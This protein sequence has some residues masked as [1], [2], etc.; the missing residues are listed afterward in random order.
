MFNSRKLA[1]SRLASVFARR[2]AAHPASAP[3]LEVARLEDRLNPAPM[4]AIQGLA[5]PGATS[6]LIGETAN[7]TFDFVNTAGGAGATDTGYAPYLEVAVDT[8]GRDG[9]GIDGNTTTPSQPND[10]FSTP[11]LTAGGLQLPPIG[12]PVVLTVGQTTYTNP[13]TGQTRPVPTGFGADDTIYVYQ[14]PFGSFTPGQRTAV[15]VSAPTSNLADVNS[16]LP[17]SFT[18]GFRDDDPGTP[19]GG[20]AGPPISGGTAATDATPELYRLRKVYLGPEDETAT[21]PNYPRTY[22]L[23]VDVATGQT[24]DNL[25][26]SDDLADSMR[27]TGRTTA[28]MSAF[29]ASSGLTN[30]VFN[31]AN[32]GGTATTAA[33]DGT[34]TYNFGSVTGVAGVDAAFEFEF[35][36]PRDRA[37]PPGGQVLPQTPTTGT[38]SVF[39]TNTASSTANWTPIDTRDPAG[40]VNK[41]ASDNGPHTLQEQSIATQ[42]SVVETDLNQNPLPSGS[43]IRPGQTLLR[44]TVNFQVSDY[45]AFQNVTLQDLIG[46]GQRLYLGAS[47]ND[48]AF[49]PTLQVSN[50]YEFATT[51]GARSNTAGAFGG[52]NILYRQLFTSNAASN[53]IGYAPAG[54]TNSAFTNLAPI[55]LANTNVYDG[56]TFLQ[57]NVSDELIRRLGADG[58]RLVGGDISNTGVGPAN[59]PFGSQLFSGTTGTIVFYAIVTDEFSD[60]FENFGNSNDPSVDQGDIL[61]NRIPLDN[62]ADAQ[63]AAGGN[64]NGFTGVRGDQINPTT[65]NAATPLVI[66]IGTDDTASAIELAVGEQQKTVYAINGTVIPTQGPGD[67]VFS[68]QAADAVTY[69]LTYTLPISRFENL[70]L[71]DL[72]PLP[73]IP[74]GPA[75]GYTFTGAAPTFTVGEIALAP[76]DTFFGTFGISPTLSTD[77]DANSL[78]LTYGSFDDVQ[79]RSTTISLLVTFRVGSQGF[80]NDLFLTNQLRVNEDTTNQ[81]TVSVEDLRRFELVRPFVTVNKGAV[82]GNGTGL[83]A[84]GIAFTAPNTAP[85]FTVGG[86]AP[87]STNALDT[88]AEAIAVGGLNVTPANLP[89]DGAD[90][91]RYA[92]VVQNTGRGDTF[93]ATIAD[94]VPDRYDRASFSGPTVFRGD[95]TLLIAGVDYTFTYNSGTGAL[96]ITLV[97]NYTAG[98]VNS[99]VTSLDNRSGALSRGEAA[100]D[101]GGAVP[102]TNGSNTI[103][104]LYDVTLLNTVAPNEL[105]VNTASV[106]VYSS[107]EGGTDLTD[108]AQVP[109]AVDPTDTANV[110]IA[111]PLQ[112]KTLVGTEVTETGNNGPNQAVIGELVT[113]TI[114]VTV[115]EG[116]TPDAVFFDQLDNGLAFVDVLSASATSGLVFSGGG[117]PT[118]GS[119]PANTTVANGGRDVAFNFG[120]ITNNTNGNNA[121]T[122]T[123]TIT[124]RAVV[125]NTNGTAGT[126]NNQGGSTRTNSAQFRWQDNQNTIQ[127]VRA[128]ESTNAAG[129]RSG[130]L[131]PVTIVEP[132]VTVDK[133]VFVNGTPDGAGD[134]GDPLQYT[135]AITNPSG[136]TGFEATFSDV[137]PFNAFGSLITGAV[138]TQTP[139]TFL[140]SDSAGVLTTADFEIVGSFATGYTIRSRAG[141]EF[142]M[143]AGRTVALEINGFISEAAVTGTTVNNIADVPYTS[144]D[145]MP[146][147]RSIHNA[148]AVER[149]GVDGRP[150]NGSNP[151]NNYVATDPAAFT[152]LQFQPQKVIVTTSEPSTPETGVGTTASPRLTAVGEIVRYRVYVQIAEGTTPNTTFVDT[153]PTGLLY[154]GNARVAL[155]A[156][157]G[158][159]SSTEFG[160]S[161]NVVGNAATLASLPSSAVMFDASGAVTTSGQT[162]TFDLGTLENADR[163]VDAEFAVI[164]FNALVQNVT[165][166]QSGT[167]RDNT[168]T[169]LVNGVQ[170]GPAS[171]TARVQVVEPVITDLAKVVNTV[172]SVSADAGDTVTFRSRFSNSG[173]ASAFD[174]V[175]TD[176]LPAADLT[177]DTGSVVVLR[178]GNPVLIGVTISTTGNTVTVT[179]DE[180]IPTDQIEI[181]YDATL[182]GSVAPNQVITTTGRVDY[183]GLPGAGT[184]AGQPGNATGQTTPGASGAANGERNGQDG[185]PTNGPLTTP[186]NNYRDTDP[187]TIAVPN[188]NVAKTL[189]TTDL[190]QTTGSNVAVGETVTYRITVTLPE[191]RT[192][193]L[194]VVD[195]LPPGMIYVPGS[196]TFITTGFGGSFDDLAGTIVQPGP[197]SGDDVV[198]T[199]F[200]INVT[201]DNNTG[202]NSFV[203]ELQAVVTNEGANEG[204]LPGQTGLPNTG[205]LQIGGGPVVNIPAVPATVVEP[206]LQVVKS[207]VNAD[208]SIDAGTTVNYQV[209][210]THTGNSTGPAFDLAVADLLSAIGMDL[211]EGS[212]VVSNPGYGTQTVTVGNTNGDTNVSIAISELRLGDTITITYSAV[213]NGAAASGPAPGSTVINTAT[214][215]YDTFPGEANPQERQEPRISDTAM[216]TVNTYSVAGNIYRDLNNNGLYEPGAWRDPD[217]RYHRTHADRGRPPGE[218]GQHPAHRDQRDVQLHRPTAEHRGR[219]HGHPGDPTDRPARRPGHG[220]DAVWRDRDTGH[221]RPWD[222]PGS[223][224]GRGPHLRGRDPAQRPAEWDGQCRGELQLRRVARGH[225]RRLRL[226]GLQRQRR[227]GRR[228]PGY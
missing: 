181:R 65:I 107:S 120:T 194:R 71:I 139:P 218:P 160:T 228:R 13:L 84:G 187:A 205:T 73:I 141:V 50:A 225:A 49:V 12:T 177:L 158:G 221:R 7:Y 176:A 22:R 28:E 81:G 11:T 26:L 214:V 115:P 149:T 103:V 14:L 199:F 110:R 212:V 118:P 136:P 82:G 213:L 96:S 72:P 208:T 134:A 68:L 87:S 195:N 222:A 108:P 184:A 137:L 53:P 198:F 27:I 60:E 62:S 123:I 132:G 95:G 41:A 203:I 38:N 155:V 45:Y 2:R 193:G 135:V 145:G 66:G 127:T 140:V 33:P 55:S 85:G 173:N 128:G 3:R 54:P 16:P 15:T 70:Q 168:F 204:V 142:D 24:L 211:V 44:Y 180:V 227:P 1:A 186:L 161:A 216:V 88:S 171:T 154:L 174:V 125:L 209:V 119:T 98:N 9:D 90:R 69:R 37:V 197:N 185:V 133:R 59:N 138:N 124:F 112:S 99:A 31:P 159:F 58:G 47:G 169:V 156:N 18:P 101:A 86:S 182:T 165:G 23:E 189:F 150:T 175:Y 147:V 130:T 56:T 192:T 35:Y 83:S 36:V 131:T 100:T 51:G 93:D 191:G 121:G 104:V 117:L 157:Q 153:L 111:L 167:N 148:A 152:V 76:D 163:D 224:P 64:P 8:S 223:G 129:T 40:P 61:R 17:I 25:V 190:V 219:V 52:G 122:E 4:P 151:L 97:D 6:I 188:G 32:D 183:T 217:R 172:E 196:A 105:I 226:R 200:G 143:T 89:V 102:I 201:G 166:N 92:V 162:I 207:V 77:T 146:G 79:D 10:G 113:Y 178:N 57:F 67:T 48:A 20:F 114:T 94:T 116:V 109:G 46:D 210:I 78:T 170:S 179:L 5:A 206:Q 164:E 39:A 43:P 126:A 202:N 19:G 220:R 91:V 75:A 21:G 74:V 63:A 144:L 30:D 215:D 80:A 106:P 29:R 42:K 34:V